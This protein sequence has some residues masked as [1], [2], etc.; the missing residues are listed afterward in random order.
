[1]AK[2][3]SPGTP[4]HQA[5]QDLC[6]DRF[7]AAGYTVEI[8]DYGSGV[9]VIGVKDG[10][11]K[12]VERVLVTA[13]YDAVPGCDGA[14]DNGTG[15]VA[16]LEA[17]RVLKD[18]TYGRTLVVACWDEEED[19]LIGAEAYAAR[20]K[21]N[22]ENIVGMVSLEMIG[23]KATAPNTQEIPTGLD[24]LFPAH[25]AD[26][27]ASGFVGDFL[28]IIPDT[29]GKA[30]GDFVAAHAAQIGLHAISLEI[31]DA[32]KNNPV[33]GDVQRSDHA[34]FWQ[35]DF[36]AMMLT[37]TSE[38]RNPNYHCGGG[39]D[40]VATLDLDFLTDNTRAIVGGTV[41]MLELR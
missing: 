19:G 6:R 5:V 34:A 14:D 24:I 40:T 1:V 29:S 30:Y 26:I 17:A 4:H 21:T 28:T 12:A 9:N 31:T 39:E 16:V 33:A 20:A 8:H 37:D 13:H 10:T 2:P 27:V 32:L 35:Q 36:P 41:D 15:T 3:R 23:F 18:A 7:E 38:F 11:D 22:G 25:Y